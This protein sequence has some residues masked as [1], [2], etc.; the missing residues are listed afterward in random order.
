MSMHPP[1]RLLV[2]VAAI[3]LLLTGL[4]GGSVAAQDGDLT[5]VCI[6][7]FETAPYV[8]YLTDEQIAELEA[9][10]DDGTD[11]P[12]PKIVGYPDPETGSCATVNGELP[13]YD[14]NVYTPICVPSG[15]DRDGPLVVQWALTHFL[16]AFSD[17]ILADP[18]TGACPGEDG[19]STGED[20]SSGEDEGASSGDDGSAAEAEDAA[21]GTASETTALPRTG[22]G[23]TAPDA[24]GQVMPAALLLIAATLVGAGI[25]TWHWRST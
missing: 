19:P 7:A 22:A 8:E 18:E 10:V 25:V 3:T 12:P 11:I 2:A 14:P 23:A 9:T 4:A 5:P 20:G 16:P 1:M 24:S 6:E 15:P 17:P 21:S 13:E